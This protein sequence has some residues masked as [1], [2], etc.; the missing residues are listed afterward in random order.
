MKITLGRL[1]SAACALLVA[2]AMLGSEQARAGEGDKGLPHLEMYFGA[3][4]G[5]HMVVGEWDLSYF[6]DEGVSPESGVI[7]GAR[8]G[9]QVTHWFGFEGELGFIPYTLDQDGGGLAMNWSLNTLWSPFDFKLSPYALVGIGMYHSAYGDLGDDADW[10]FHWGLGLRAMLNEWVAFRLE[11]RH[12]VT[13]SYSV[14][15]ASNVEWTLGV[16]VFPW[17]YTEGEKDLDGDGLIGK[18]DDCPTIPGPAITRG[19]PDSDGDGVRDSEDRCPTMPGLPINQG[20]PDTDGDGIFDDVDACPTVPGVPEHRGCPAPVQDSDGD[21]IPDSEDKCPTVKGVKEAQGCLPQEFDKF[22]GAVEDINFDTNKATLKP[23]SFAILDEAVK[24]LQQYPTIRI[25]IH[26]HT[27]S[28]GPDAHNQ[29]LSE[30]RAAAVRQ[31]LVDK[32]IAPER[33]TARGFGESEPIAP[34][35]TA[36]GRAKNRRVEIE[37]VG[38]RQK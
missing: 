15:S 12:I 29:K 35:N 7:F 31:Y 27:D 25:D 32:G 20:C 34:N 4:G 11:G 21:G 23:K 10:D 22:T 18:D 5:L 33:L 28:Q 6:A 8:V 30:D 3:F 13:D 9:L 26:G 37:V 14:G 2:T 24:L 19:C 36:A 1:G 16:D 17:S 38:T